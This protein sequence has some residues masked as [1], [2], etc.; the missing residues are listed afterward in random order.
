MEPTSLELTV[1]SLFITKVNGEKILK[2]FNVMKYW[3]IELK[4]Y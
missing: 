3:Y 2:I 4:S 1:K